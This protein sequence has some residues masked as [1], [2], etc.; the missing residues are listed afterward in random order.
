[1]PAVLGY[2]TAMLYNQN[3]VTP[4]ASPLTSYIEYLVGQQ[5][6]GMLGYTTKDHFDKDASLKDQPVGWGHIT[7]DGSIANLESMW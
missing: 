2:L 6:C 4:E 7:A 5:L 3:N 1:M